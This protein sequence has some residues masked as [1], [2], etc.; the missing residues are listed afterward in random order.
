MNYSVY[1]VTKEKTAIRGFWLDAGRVYRD[2][3]KVILTDESGFQSLRQDLFNKGEKAVFA[4]QEGKA[5]IV[6]NTNGKRDTLN[7]RKAFYFERLKASQIKSL[8]SKYS[9]LTIFKTSG[10]PYLVEIWSA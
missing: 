10:N 5:A 3:I 6:D 4:I 9:G 2:R 7:T 1:T 8:L